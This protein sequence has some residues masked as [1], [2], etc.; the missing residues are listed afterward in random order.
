MLF[1]QRADTKR[2]NLRFFVKLFDKKGFLH[3]YLKSSIHF[4]SI[5][6][7]GNDKKLT[8]IDLYG[9]KNLVTRSMVRFLA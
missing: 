2:L 8:P 9:E 1:Y 7:V 4:L 3:Y 5:L 6:R